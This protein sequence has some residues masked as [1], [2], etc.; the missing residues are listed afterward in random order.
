M[1]SLVWTSTPYVFTSEP[2]GKRVR[3]LNHMHDLPLLSDRILVD[4]SGELV[5]H[6]YMVD[7]GCST[8]FNVN[9]VWM[10]GVINDHIE[11]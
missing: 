8:E 1:F 7:K 5:A 6:S 2:I 9:V 3:L 4:A 11:S 10:H